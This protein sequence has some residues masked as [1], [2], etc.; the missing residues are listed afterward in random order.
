M[1]LVTLFNGINV[2]QTRDYINI[3]EETYIECICAKY[4]ATWVN[5]GRDKPTT[6]LPN[7]K[8]FI[9]G[10]LSAVGDDDPL[11]QHAMAKEMGVGYRSD[12]G[13]IIFA[14]VTARPDLCHAGAQGCHNTI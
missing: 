6:P 8:E 13:E 5:G 4:L 10:F 2:L 9:C 7:K 12:V 14:M 11:T 1:G 3:S